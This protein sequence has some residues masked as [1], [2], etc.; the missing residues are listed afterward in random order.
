MQGAGKGAEVYCPD[1]TLDMVAAYKGIKSRLVDSLTAR[2]IGA[3]TN[4]FSVDLEKLMSTQVS[5]LADERN[6]EAVSN[7]WQAFFDDIANIHTTGTSAKSAS[8]VSYSTHKHSKEPAENHTTS[9]DLEI[10]DSRQPQLE[11]M[12]DVS[13]DHVNSEYE[14]RPVVK[15]SKKTVIKVVYGWTCFTCVE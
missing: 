11:V 9:E 14:S 10:E 1:V 6:D 15:K 12:E 8:S 5:G 2:G 13:D 3:D 7:V 4:N